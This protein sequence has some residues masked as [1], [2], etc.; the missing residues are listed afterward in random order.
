MKNTKKIIAILLSFVLTVSLF[1]FEC[2]VKSEAVIK[3]DTSQGNF[4]IHTLDNDFKDGK[5]RIRYKFEYTDVPVDVYAI[6]LSNIRLENSSGKV[7][8]TWKDMEILKGGGSLVKNFGVDF[9]VLPSDT[10]SFRF[11]VAPLYAPGH[12]KSFTR[13]IEH[14]GGEITYSKA[15]YTTNTNGAKILYIKFKVKMLSGK[16]PKLQIYDANKNLIYTGKSKKTINGDDATWTWKWD[17][18]AS[19]G[20]LID[21]GTYIFKMTCG[22]KSCVK[23]ININVD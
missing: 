2:P 11:T 16:S 21:S 14:K 4:T 5:Y 3:Y 6:T 1:V 20:F 23:K 12:A 7:V 18:I 15:G 9:S 8:G 10:Y 22:G 17:M 19:D 13:K